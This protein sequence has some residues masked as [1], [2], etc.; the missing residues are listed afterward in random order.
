MKGG[1]HSRVKGRIG[2]ALLFTP[3]LVEKRLEL[4]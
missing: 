4:E 2:S 3:E 1:S